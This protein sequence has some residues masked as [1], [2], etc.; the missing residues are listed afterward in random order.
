MHPLTSSGTRAS[1]TSANKTKD[2]MC[3]QIWSIEDLDGII[4]QGVHRE[5]LADWNKQQLSAKYPQSLNQTR[6]YRQNN[7]APPSAREPRCSLCSSVSR[8]LMVRDAL[9][10]GNSNS[11]YPEYQIETLNTAAL[12]LSGFQATTRKSRLDIS[13]ASANVTRRASR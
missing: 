7:F 5:G 3:P 13:R 6:K 8:A 12:I 1:H 4:K 2:Q 9:W 11:T 10:S